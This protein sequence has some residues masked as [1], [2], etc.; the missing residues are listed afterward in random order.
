M[1]TN[2]VWTVLITDNLPAKFLFMSSQFRGKLQLLLSESDS[3]CG[4]ELQEVPMHLSH[5]HAD[6]Y[7]RL[8]R[9]FVRLTNHDTSHIFSSAVPYINLLLDTGLP[10][11][12]TQRQRLQTQN[13]PS[14]RYVI[15]WQAESTQ[16]TS[17]VSKYHMSSMYIRYLKKKYRNKEE[18]DDKVDVGRNINLNTL[19]RVGRGLVS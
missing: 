18:S 8:S 3:I 12:E 17:S 7:K 19:G 5:N 1:Y 2:K 14:I 13:L 6:T 9:K 15:E 16:I 10:F 4:C 11:L